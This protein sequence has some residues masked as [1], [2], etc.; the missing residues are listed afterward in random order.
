MKHFSITF[1]KIGFIGKEWKNSQFPE[2]WFYPGI[3]PKPNF[4]SGSYLTCINKHF[5]LVQRNILSKLVQTNGRE[6]Y[7]SM[8][9]QNT[10]FSQSLT[11]HTTKRTCSFATIG[12][13]D[14]QPARLRINLWMEMVECR[15]ASESSSPWRHHWAAHS[16]MSADLSGLPWDALTTLSPKLEEL[17]LSVLPIPEHLNDI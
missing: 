13:S 7:F 11:Q 4:S 8:W 2:R 1:R 3:H 17:A 6:G 16:T 12:C 15:M 9:A 5:L 14:Q 10:S